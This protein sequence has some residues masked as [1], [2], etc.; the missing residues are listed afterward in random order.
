MKAVNKAKDLHELKNSSN[1]TPTSNNQ[2]LFVKSDKR[3]IKLDFLDIF[4][5]ES[6]G[7]Y[8]KVWLENEYHLTPNTLSSFAASLPSAFYRIHKSFV[9]NLRQIDYLEA[10]MVTLKNGKVLPV[11]KNHRQDFK[12][13]VDKFKS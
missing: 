4:Y 1:S 3:T 8:V 5:L 11:G 7:N 2:Y 12:A 6:Y 13:F 9:I 10:N